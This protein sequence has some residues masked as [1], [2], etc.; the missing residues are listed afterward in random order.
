[1]IF[2]ESAWLAP[3]GSDVTISF[4]SEAEDSVGQE[5]IQ[6]KVVWHCPQDDEFKNRA[7]FGVLVQR[8]W[9]Q[10]RGPDILSE[11]EEAV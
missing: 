4:L 9:P 1:M 2:V 6:G 3:I 5:F 10:S 8:Q 7:G 11:P